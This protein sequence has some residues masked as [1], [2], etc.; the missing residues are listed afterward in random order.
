VVFGDLR[1]EDARLKAVVNDD[2]AQ[3]PHVAES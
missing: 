3:F 2:S 1:V